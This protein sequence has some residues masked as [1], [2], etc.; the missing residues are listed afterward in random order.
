MC[1]YGQQAMGRGRRQCGRAQKEEKSVCVCLSALSLRRLSP[2]LS[3]LSPSQTEMQA[4]APR[5]SLAPRPA[6]PAVGTARRP[7]VVMAASAGREEAR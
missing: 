6:A 2:L 7:S 1:A 3:L 4:L 5:P